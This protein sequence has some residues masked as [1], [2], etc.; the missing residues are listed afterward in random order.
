MPYSEQY[1]FR[2]KTAP[3][4]AIAGT[5]MARV[6][7]EKKNDPYRCRYTIKFGKITF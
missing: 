3:R 5:L 2:P 6:E 7:S 4:P 1:C